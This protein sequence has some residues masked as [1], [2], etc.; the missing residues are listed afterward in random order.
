MISQAN[1]GGEIFSLKGK[2]VW[3][4]GHNGLV[5]SALVHRLEREE[6][7]ILKVSHGELDLTRQADTERWMAKSRPEVVL[8]AAAKVGGIAANSAYPADFLYI[9]AMI[10]MNI[11]KAA[12]DI[13]TEKLLWMGS[14]CIYPKFAAQPIDEHALLTG[15]LEPT[16]EPYAIAKIAAL[17][18]AQ[19]YAAQYG[20]RSISVMPTNLYGRNDNF[21]PQGSHVIP[22]MVRKMHEA[23]VA[24][25]ET[26]T[27]WGT[28]NPLREFLHV[29][30][31]ADACVLLMKTH[32]HLQLINVGSG[33]EV[34][35]R[36]LAY[37]VADI[38]GYRGQIVFDTSKPDGTPRKRLNSLR[39]HALGWT[40][41]VDLRSG[42]EDLYHHW[43]PRAGQVAAE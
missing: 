3:V 23:K 11:M 40:P 4:A 22:A 5:G 14:S 25:S 41:K 43:R 7:T 20:T 15:P 28:G 1:P 27:V 37:L 12:T 34:S 19:A 8:V 26:V 16:N 39:L 38:V 36:D 35:I 18:L 13:G 9:N 31:L 42:I 30:D 33:Q 29:D 32:T 24:D 2:R 21:D 10:A 17:K 6:C